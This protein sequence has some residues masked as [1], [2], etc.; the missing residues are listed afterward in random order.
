MLFFETKY[1]DIIWDQEVG[2]VILKWKGYA[3][4]DQF[5]EAMDKG[6]E[7]LKSKKANKWLGDCTNF[8]TLKKPDEEWSNTSW[9]PRAIQSG[10]NKIA[11]VLPINTIQKNIVD[12]VLNGNGEEVIQAGKFTNYEEALGWLKG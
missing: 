8:V 3:S 1:C 5:K 4:S 12:R 7:L 9:S 6:L 10:L 11:I 2:A